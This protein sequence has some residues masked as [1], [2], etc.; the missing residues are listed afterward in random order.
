MRED[1]HKRLVQA[2]AIRKMTAQEL[3]NRT[4]I[5]KALISGYINQKYIARQDKLTSMAET[6]C[7][8]EGWLMGYNVPMEKN[9]KN[10]VDNNVSPLISNMKVLPVLGKISAGL[11]IL[12][13]ENIIGYEATSTTLLKEGFNYF[14]L[15][16][17]GDSMNL[18]IPEGSIILV[19]QQDTLENDEIG[20][21]LI[22]DDATV[23]KYKSD[24]GLVVLYPM[25]TNPKHEIQIYNPK[26]VNIKILGKV[27]SFQG[28]V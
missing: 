3:A 2:L 10:I 20:V 24:N 8:N 27:V 7:V 26:K 28:K 21:F 16:V 23:K 11:P 1:F 13:V 17:Q 19:Q 12:A 15:L 22:E 14:Y 18:K 9:Y 25:S 4:G 5:S 6:L